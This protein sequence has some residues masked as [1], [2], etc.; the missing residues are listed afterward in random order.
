VHFSYDTHN[1]DTCEDHRG[2]FSLQCPTKGSKCGEADRS[3][4]RAEMQFRI[5]G[6]FFA[7]RRPSK[8]GE[9]HSFQ[10]NHRCFKLPTF[11]AVFHSFT[12]HFSIQ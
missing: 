5:N 9:S 7:N 11:I 12:V 6:D 1:T 10:A 8:G 3:D 4:G 2:H